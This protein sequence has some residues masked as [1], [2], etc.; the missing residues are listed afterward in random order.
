MDVPEVSGFELIAIVIGVVQFIKEQLELVDKP[1]QRLTLGVGLVVFGY[2]SA[3]QAGVVPEAVVL[4]ASIVIR[5]I[6]YTLAVPGLY[7]VVKH[8]LLNRK[9]E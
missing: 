2:W 9:G 3:A 8:E 7:K 6:G 5:T 1:A 4:W